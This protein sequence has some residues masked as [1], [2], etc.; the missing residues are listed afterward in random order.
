MLVGNVHDTKESD[1][2][3]PIFKNVGGRNIQGF[4]H[5]QNQNYLVTESLNM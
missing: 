2:F 3:N 1:M 4:E 5:L